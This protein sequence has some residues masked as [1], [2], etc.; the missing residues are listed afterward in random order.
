MQTLPVVRIDAHNPSPMTGEGN[1]TY[2]VPVAGTAV[3]VD[4]GPGDPSFSRSVARELDLAQARLVAVVVTHAHADHAAGAEGLARSYP[5]ASFFKYPWPQEDVRFRVRWQAVGEGDRV[6]VGGGVDLDI[7]STPG[8]SPDHIALWHAAS[9]TVFTGDLVTAGGSVMIQA[10]RGGSLAQ[11][12]ASLERIRSLA[13][14]RL[15][16]A[17]GPVVE[18]PDAVLA[19]HIAHRL[20][21]ERQVA[22]ALAMGRSSLQAIAETIYHGLSPA[23]L[24][25]AHENVR[26]HLEKLEQEGRAFRDGDRWTA[27]QK[28]G[29]RSNTME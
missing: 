5:N 29:Q 14:V 20:V 11:Y 16:P 12:L 4:A 18:D 7:L 9:R 27:R 2:L 10:S 6:D 8:H 28:D 22:E 13:P 25:A 23:L 21:R 15:F 24:A 19:E 3:L 17:H 1:H 26:A